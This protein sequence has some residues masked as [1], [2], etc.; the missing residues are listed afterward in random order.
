MENRIKIILAED[1][2][3]YRKKIKSALE[4]SN[5]EVIA[6]AVN[7]S[8]LFKHLE[9]HSPDVILLDL[10]MPDMNGS[11]A[12][13]KLSQEYPDKKVII[14]SSFSEQVLIDDFRERGAK[15]YISKDHT[16]EEQLIKIIKKVSGGGTYFFKNNERPPI[17]LSERQKDIVHL[18]ANQTINKE[19]IGEKIGMTGNGVGKQEKKIMKKMRARNLPA[20][21]EYIFEAGLKFL[22]PPKKGKD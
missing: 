21:F 10:R 15:G 22:R 20:Y 4:S 7:G 18:S 13:S 19:E 12:M 16:D 9:T 11:I 8:H 1:H 2:E 6:E 14:L 3:G 5:I 17:K